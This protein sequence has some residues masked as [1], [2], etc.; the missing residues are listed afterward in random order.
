M[1][2]P[3]QWMI[4]WINIK[5]L[6]ETFSFTNAMNTCTAWKPKPV[7]KRRT[8]IGLFGDFTWVIGNS[9]ACFLISNI[10]IFAKYFN[11]SS[12]FL[13]TSFTLV[14]N[15]R[16][17]VIENN[18]KTF[19][20]IFNSKCWRTFWNNNSTRQIWSWTCVGCGKSGIST[21]RTNCSL[22]STF[23]AFLKVKSFISW[24]VH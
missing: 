10:P 21:R 2:F 6:N 24:E 3:Y 5:Y 11:I 19:L 9:T 1:T 7:S 4:K 17:A 13:L 16:I 15:T 22:L 8:K 12:S 14:E 18:L 20:Y 23:Y